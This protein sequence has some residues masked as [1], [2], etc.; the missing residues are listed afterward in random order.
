MVNVGGLFELGQS[1]ARQA[2]TTA[3]TRVANIKVEAST[4]PETLE[5]VET[6]TDLWE[7]DGIVITLSPANYVPVPGL[8]IKLGDWRI[9]VLPETQIPVEG[10]TVEVRSSMDPNLPTQR[11]TV[12]GTVSTS[13]GAI[14]DIYAR[15][16]K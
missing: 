1:L 12:L 15:P 4:D 8:D 2:I 9:I 16:T 3:G 7:A 6:V 5:R 14:L 10:S 13:A 11:G